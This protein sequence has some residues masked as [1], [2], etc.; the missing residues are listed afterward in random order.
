MPKSVTA[1]ILGSL[2]FAGLSLT[3]R[4]AGRPAPAPELAGGTKWLNTPGEAP[5]TLAALRGKV[6]LVEFW[7]GGCNN[8]LNTLPYVKRW[9]ARYQGQGFVVVGVHSPEFQHEHAEAYVRNRISALGVRYPVVMD[10]GF[11][12]WRAYNNVYWPTTYLVDKTGRLRY[13]QIGE[14]NYDVTEATIRRL[15]AEPVP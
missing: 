5:L 4:A 2:L 7:T 12:I 8:C 14:G 10:N 1:I 15:L 9:F 13:K 6:V 3:G 11:R